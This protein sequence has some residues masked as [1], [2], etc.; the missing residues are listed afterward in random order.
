MPSLRHPYAGATC[1]TANSSARRLRLARRARAPAHV[2]RPLLLFRSR[3][4]T[5]S[6]RP[7]RAYR[8]GRLRSMLSLSGMDLSWRYAQQIRKNIDRPAPLER[9]DE[10]IAASA[11]RLGRGAAVARKR[12]GCSRRSRGMLANIERLGSADQALSGLAFARGLS[13]A[14][15]RR[16]RREQRLRS[17]P[18][19]M[20]P[21]PAVA[22][23][24]DRSRPR[25]AYTY[26][27]R[28]KR[29]TQ[30]QP[31]LW[32][33][34]AELKGQ[35]V[36]GDLAPRSAGSVATPSTQRRR[37]SPWPATRELRRVRPHLQQRRREL[38]PRL[39]WYGPETDSP[40]RLG[41]PLQSPD[42]LSWT[43]A[44]RRGSLLVISSRFIM[45]ERVSPHG[46][47]PALYHDLAALPI[48]GVPLYCWS[49]A[50]CSAERAPVARDRPR[51]CS[52]VKAARAELL[53][54]QVTHAGRAHS[55]ACRR[56]AREVRLFSRL[57]RI[58]DALVARDRA[59]APPRPLSLHLPRRPHWHRIVDALVE[60]RDGDRGAA[61]LD[62]G[63]AARRP[64][65]GDARVGVEFTSSTRAAP[66]ALARDDFR[67]NPTRVIDGR[68]GHRRMNVT[69]DHARALRGRL[70]GGTPTSRSPPPAVHACRLPSSRTGSS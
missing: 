56:R 6:L 47:H 19:L 37:L 35:C 8:R 41:S 14:A 64:F 65:A 58:Y 62:G 30:A 9:Q 10:P 18:L 69:D 40:P 63:A 49:A 3:R 38:H 57:R 48:V 60:P 66:F 54:L 70:P 32:F 2:D 12:T 31:S 11:L 42:T 22:P 28:E 55:Q 33:E 23:I 44:R 29:L 67:T 59:G 36:S 24:R 13:S 39:L 17:G 68:W 5:A 1:L 27:V 43:A 7:A 25:R 21:T 20:G 26:V 4:L 50:R 51:G 46:D 45:R 61:A 16:R 52:G 34:F 15:R 53:S